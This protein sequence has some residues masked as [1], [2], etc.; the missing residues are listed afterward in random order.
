M[1]GPYNPVDPNTSNP[2]TV[3]KVYR[4]IYEMT[5]YFLVF[6][7]T[8][9]KYDETDATYLVF[10]KEFN[11]IE[12]RALVLP[13]AYQAMMDLDAK[14]ARTYSDLRELEKK[15]RAEQMSSVLSF[16]GFRKDPSN[17]DRTH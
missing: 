2:Y 3:E 11:T 9:D 5:H 14:L 6:N 15:S 4:K 7:E 8:Y 12:Y 1:D 10:N 17:N 13:M 16:N